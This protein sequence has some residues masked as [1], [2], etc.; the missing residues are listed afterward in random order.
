MWKFNNLRLWYQLKHLGLGAAGYTCSLDIHFAMKFNPSVHFFKVNY[1]LI[2]TPIL[3]NHILTHTK[4][5]DR[6][7]KT[8]HDCSPIYNAIR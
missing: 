7:D 4:K 3:R 6:F 8:I 1:K 5:H 2:S